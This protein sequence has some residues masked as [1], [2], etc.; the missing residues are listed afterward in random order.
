[1]SP[2]SA[3]MFMV[4][5]LGFGFAGLTAS[6]YRLATSRLPAFEML[7]GGPSVGTFAVVPL[8]MASA[9][10]LIM[11][12]TL[13]GRRQESRRFEFVFLA[14]TIAGFWSLMS[15]VVLVSALHACGFLIA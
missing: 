1:M 9:P 5:A 6:A 8:L 10:F 4:L 14:T 2:H 3:H 15:G 11:R 12:N 13:L 7:S